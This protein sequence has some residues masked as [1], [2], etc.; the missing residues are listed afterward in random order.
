V[1]AAAQ[2]YR[3]VALTGAACYVGEGRNRYS[4]LHIDDAA[5]LCAA[6]VDRAPAGALYH[7]VGGEIAVRTLAEAVARDLG[8]PT[9]SLSRADAEQVWGEFDALILGSSSRTRAVRAGAELGWSPRHTDMLVEV[10]EPR[11]RALATAQPSA[12]TTQR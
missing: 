9:R 3:S 4:D 11:L 12:A 5:R 2:I 6:A 8:R 1:V 10:G 7:G